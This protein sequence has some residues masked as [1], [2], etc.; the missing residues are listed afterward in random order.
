MKTDNLTTATF[1]QNSYIACVAAN[2][3]KLAIM[4][5]FHMKKYDL[6]LNTEYIIVCITEYCVIY[7]SG[8]QHG[9]INKEGSAKCHLKLGILH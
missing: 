9:D 4:Q 3:N 8:Y 2:L 1:S 5:T 6:T 7:I